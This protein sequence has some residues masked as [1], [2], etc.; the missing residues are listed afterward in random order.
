VFPG[1]FII[2]AMNDITREIKAQEALEDAINNCG[3]NPKRFAESTTRWHRYIQ[4][5]LF[6][7]ALWI[8]R[9]YGSN[10]YRF[11]LRN[12]YAHETAKKILQTGVLD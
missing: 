3:F 10:E 7:L 8:I 1:F 5:E 6:K 2:T 9:I 4:N 11:D 12:E